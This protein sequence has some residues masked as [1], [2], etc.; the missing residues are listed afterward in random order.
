MPAFVAPGQAVSGF[1]ACCQSR[2]AFFSFF[3]QPGQPVVR[4]NAVVVAE[5]GRVEGAVRREEALAVSLPAGVAEG[6]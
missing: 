3:S 6:G 1:W 5:E 4:L 2:T